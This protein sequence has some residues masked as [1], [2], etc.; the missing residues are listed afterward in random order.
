MMKHCLFII[1]L[2]PACCAFSQPTNHDAE[3]MQIK[4]KWTKHANVIG[5][6][7][8]DFPKSQYSIVYKKTDSMTALLKRCYPDPTGLE[9]RYYTTVG[10]WPVCKGA[11]ASYT[12]TSMYMSY[13][14]NTHLNKIL[15]ADETSTVVRVH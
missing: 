11:P 13:Y 9:A 10:E 14:F 4:G 6:N 3:I 2:L 1:L 8:P 7:D 12:L 15:L 5:L